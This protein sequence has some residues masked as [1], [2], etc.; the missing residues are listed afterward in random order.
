MKMKKIGLLFGMAIAALTLSTSCSK[1]DKSNCISCKQAGQ[2]QKI[3]DTSTEFK[4][5]NMTWADFKAMVKEADDAST[6]ITCT[7]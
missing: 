5:L 2:T 6:D 3:C 1:D 4:N 7:Y